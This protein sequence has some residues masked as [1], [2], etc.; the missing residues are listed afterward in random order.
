ML[1]FSL[2]TYINTTQT[3]Y[4]AA[5]DTT[6]RGAGITQMNLPESL[7]MSLIGMGVVMLAL[8]AIMALVMVQSKAVKRF[9]SVAATPGSGDVPVQTPTLAAA[10]SSTVEKPAGTVARIPAPGAMGEV[11][12][13][14]VPEQTAALLMAIVADEMKAPLNELRFISIKEV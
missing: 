7:L 10:A 11:K 1:M 14:N 9:T 5:A 6:A 4:A 3:A 8:T 2:S 12:L 13:Y